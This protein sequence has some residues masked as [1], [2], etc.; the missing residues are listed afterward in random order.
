MKFGILPSPNFT[1]WPALRDIGRRIDELGYSSLWCSDHLY[2]P[3]P[4]TLGPVY[5]GYMVLA[6]WSAVTSRVSLGLMVGSNNFRNPAMV[7]KMVTTL[8]HQSDGRAV[9][10]VGAGWFEG[11]HR[12]FGHPF[13]PPA[14]RLARLDEALDI[15]RAMLDGK[16]ASGTRFYTHD[17]VENMPGTVQ[18]RIPILIGGGGEKKTLRIVA[19]HADI[20]NIAGAFDDIRRKDG[21]LREHC[22]AIGR[23]SAEIERNYHAGPIFIRDDVDEV[24]E[25]TE[26]TFEHHGLS[27]IYPPLMGT[28]EQLVAQLLPVAELGFH[29][30]YFDL[31]SPYDDESLVRMITEVKPMLESALGR[32]TA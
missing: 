26:R 6:G 18:P 10:S 7:V 29:S 21:V 11:E 25:L 28:P 15:M 4:A 5:E 8:D 30:M 16:P 17:A 20:W 13:D 1:T 9:L 31:V 24:M 12:A 19:R 3:Y 23:D 2:A 32:S 14:D 27:G 22:A